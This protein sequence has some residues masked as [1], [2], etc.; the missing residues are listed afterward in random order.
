MS[1]RVLDAD[2]AMVR[3]KAVRRDTRLRDNAL[4]VLG[5]GLGRY[6]LAFDFGE[7]GKVAVTGHDPV[8]PSADPDAL[9]RAVDV[10]NVA[11][12]AGTFRISGVYVTTSETLPVG[13]EGILV[14][15]LEACRQRLIA[16][17]DAHHASF[18][19]PGRQPFGVH[20]GDD[21]VARIVPHV[22]GR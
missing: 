21:G 8:G 12:G 6:R 11:A 1:A 9:Q 2:Q 5:Q 15:D 16:R 22:S 18:E 7:D 20:V 19:A 13:P 4:D 17:L 10:A 14:E 3:W